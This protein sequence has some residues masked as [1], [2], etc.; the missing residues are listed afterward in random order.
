MPCFFVISFLSFFGFQTNID[1]ICTQL[2][3]YFLLGSFLFIEREPYRPVGWHRTQ[4]D[5]DGSFF[6]SKDI[7]LRA[8][9]R[10][11]PKYD[12]MIPVIFVSSRS[13]EIPRMNNRMTVK[14]KN[15]T[16]YHTTYRLVRWLRHKHLLP[17]SYDV[18]NQETLTAGFY[19]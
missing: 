12:N 11:P 7:P 1:L 8:L 19:C 17:Y 18:M 2:V 15:T 3:L 13:W 9:V 10:N 14:W 6:V 5:P 16:P 4:I